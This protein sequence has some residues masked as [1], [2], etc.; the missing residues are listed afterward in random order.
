MTWDFFKKTGQIKPF[1]SIEEFE[2]FTEDMIK[3][4]SLETFANTSFRK[5]KIKKGVD[6]RSI[7][8]DSFAEFTFVQYYRLIEHITVERNYKTQFL[9]YIDPD[10]KIRK[11]YPDFILG[12]QFAEVKGRI[13]AK[14]QCK[15][16]QCTNVKW[17]FQSDINEMASILDKSGIDWRSDF[18]QTN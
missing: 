7:Q 13:S 10:G 16:D 15:F 3:L 14:D 9:T 12:G 1:N 17:F 5:S 18:I 4:P 8:Y 11:F 2:K 6:I